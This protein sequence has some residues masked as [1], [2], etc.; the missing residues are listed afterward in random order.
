[1][2]RTIKSVEDSRDIWMTIAL[3]VILG[4][5]LSFGAM[6]LQKG[7]LEDLQNELESLR[8]IHHELVDSTH[9]A[10]TGDNFQ[11]YLNGDK[12]MMN[13]VENGTISFWLNHYKEVPK[14]INCSEIFGVRIDEWASWNRTLPISGVRENE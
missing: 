3:S 11:I 4:L 8:N 2:K 14:S 10:V 5:F 9:L 7:N 13:E 1:M 12:V 6:F